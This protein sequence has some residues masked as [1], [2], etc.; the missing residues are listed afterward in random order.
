V[1]FQQWDFRW[2]LGGMLL[3]RLET[4]GRSEG[5]YLVVAGVLFM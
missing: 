1:D 4:V 2:G 5:C 3:R